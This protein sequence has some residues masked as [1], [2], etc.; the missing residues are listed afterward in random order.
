MNV[1]ACCLAALPLQILALE[2][3]FAQSATGASE[4]TNDEPA[5]SAKSGQNA[6]PQ[7]EVIQKQEASKPT[8][9]PA[10]AKAA[11]ANGGQA[12]GLPSKKKSARPIAGLAGSSGELTT[13]EPGKTALSAAA[14]ALPATTTT[15]GATAIG[16]MPITSYGDLFRSLPG[17]NV[18]NYGQ[19]AIGYGLSMRG[20]TDGEHGRD[21]AYFIDGMPINEVSSLH[22][23][24][25]AD[26]NILLPGS[27]RDI[28]IVR[29]PFSV[30]YGDSNLGG[31]ISITTK[32]AEPFA[33]ASVSGG[34]FGT[35]EGIVS[36]SSV[37]GAYLPF[38]MYEGYHT[39]GYQD[40]SYVDRYNAFNKVTLPRSDGSALSV[41]VQAY[42]TE[43]GA[44]GYVNRS[45]LEAGK[46]AATAAVNPT[47][48]GEVYEQN[49]VTNYVSGADNNGT[50][51]ALFVAHRQRDRYS[52]FGGG[53]RLQRD[54]RTFVG[55]RA[56]EVWTAN[57]SDHMPVQFLVGANW[58]TDFIDTLQASTVAR[59][60][61]A[62][63]VDVG[64]NETNLGGF[65]QVQL[66][67]MPWLK[68]TGGGRID[69][70]FYD[71]DNRLDP[72]NEPD[73]SPHIWSPKAGIAITPLSWMEVYANYGEG[74][75]SP[76]AS[77]EVLD[78][79]AIQP[80]K[81]D[82]K[83]IGINLRFDRLKVSA[84]Y[85][86]TNSDNESFQPAPGLPVTFLGHALREGYDIDVRV[87]VFKET[88]GV[89]TLFANYG[90]V[91]A[92]LL[93]AAPSYFVPNVPDYVGSIGV[94]FDIAT[95]G[96]Q[97]LSGSTYITFIGEKNLS[98]DGLL[99]TSPY[100]RV[101][102]RLAYAW[103]E[104]GWI[105]FAQATWYPGDR[106]S[107]TAFNFGDPTG[108]S[109]SDIFVGPVP[110]AVA[111]AGLT[112]RLPTWVGN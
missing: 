51:A 96:S 47:D 35:A 4:P 95:T 52:D 101:T 8:V 29:G 23:P 94:D 76:S 68:L 20:Y 84:D 36:Y 45:D 93:D 77:S 109:A 15:I 63:K 100:E 50:R 62:T 14:S 69:Q 79:P 86:T 98:Q 22:T 11:A 56:R 31:S 89:V 10:K 82:S 88:S 25:Y 71:I 30:E 80:F 41:R 46:V 72:S 60:I 32:T 38:L 24:N 27:V 26:L 112:Y 2:Q 70:F 40:N 99:T 106:F 42:G 92:R 59:T 75:R 34:S 48:G 44:P 85:Y 65:A 13:I 43:F 102:G 110:E 6:L 16:R 19:G 90:A 107:E 49:L 64:I 111:M 5:P 33:A 61:T 28:E 54:E 83:E 108:A 87:D 105:A 9:K 91:E 97:R 39:D 55:G 58:R 21:I 12:P 3:A 67:P 74:F 66:K 53:Q 78:N 57:L 104:D 73:I 81:I 18:S 17:F 1:A 103:P 37:N 7:V